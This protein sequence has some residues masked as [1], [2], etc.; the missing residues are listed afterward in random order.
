MLPTW[1]QDDVSEQ[2]AEAVEHI[3]VKKTELATH[4]AAYAGAL[5]Y[6][7]TLEHMRQ[8][9]RREQ[10]TFDTTLKA[11]EKLLGVREKQVH[12]ALNQVDRVRRAR[13]AEIIELR[14]LRRQFQRER[15]AA[16][17]KLETRKQVMEEKCVRDV[18]ARG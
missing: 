14:R 4:R 12:D 1:A 13:D 18:W 6:R 3:A 15:E 9:L 10:L 16:E 8:R 7:R 17:R 5:Q 2:R 11:Y